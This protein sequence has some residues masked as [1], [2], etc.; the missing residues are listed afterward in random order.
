MYGLVFFQYRIF[1]NLVLETK[2]T[3]Q[4]QQKSE[5]F[6]EYLLSYLEDEFGRYED[7]RLRKV[8]PPTQTEKEKDDDEFGG[9]QQKQD[10][11]FS[12]RAGISV[13]AVGRE[14]FF[15]L[16]W[17]EQKSFNLVEAEVRR[18]KDLLE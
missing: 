14:Y 12:E 11:I 16:K 10:N 18:I 7:V 17:A 8:L 5:Y 1:E 2:S 13:R 9:P 6:L 4:Q 3:M 15:P